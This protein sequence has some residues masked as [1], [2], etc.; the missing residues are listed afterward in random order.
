MIESISV[1]LKN[2]PVNRQLYPRTSSCS[3]QSSRTEGRSWLALHSGVGTELN[4]I[5]LVIQGN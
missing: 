1:C 5:L 2:A 4:E 3:N